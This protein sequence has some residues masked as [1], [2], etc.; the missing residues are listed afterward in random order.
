MAHD[1]DSVVYFWRDCYLE[2]ESMT[3]QEKRPK[4][5]YLTGMNPTKI[6]FFEVEI[7]CHGVK[8]PCPLD[9]ECHINRIKKIIVLS[10]QKFIT[11]LI[12]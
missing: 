4:W 9:C 6:S 7:S 10:A 5:S 2:L 12:R 11:F 1:D 3:Q 8:N